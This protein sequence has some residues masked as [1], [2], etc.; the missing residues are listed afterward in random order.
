M[1]RNGREHCSET[2]RFA[3]TPDWAKA[4]IKRGVYAIIHRDSGRA[5]IG[6][7]V[8]VPARLWQH[9][10]QLNRA[11]SPH[12]VLQEAWTEHGADAFEIRIVDAVAPEDSILNR[13]QAWMERFR[14]D[15][16][17]LNSHPRA[18]TALG[19]VRPDGARA[20]IAGGKTG[21]RN[22]SAKLSETDASIIRGRLEA[23]ESMSSIARDYGVSVT[24]I[25]SIKR[26]EWGTT[27]KRQKPRGP[28]RT[29]SAEVVAAIRED[30]L[31]I[32]NPRLIAE[33]H[34]VSRSAVARILQG[35]T[36]SHDT[37]S[38]ASKS[39]SNPVPADC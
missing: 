26:G 13:E 14:G 21:S 15:A 24:P 37:S 28:S 17:L 30:S 22:P 31:T 20:A 5:Y 32:T 1:V 4:G 19:T 36:H 33:R 29:L 8:D 18:D 9:I 16:G 10:R 3:A 39:P 23:G 38:L 2:C 34:G 35:K 12:R 6:S 7:S 25:Y 11:V 27:G